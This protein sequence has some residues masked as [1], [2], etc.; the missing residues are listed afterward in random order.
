MKRFVT[1]SIKKVQ[2]I[3]NN[4]PMFKRHRYAIECE[5]ITKAYDVAKDVYSFDGIQ[6]LRISK[7]I[8]DKT[9]IILPQKYYNII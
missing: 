5:N 6:Y 4:V 7:T 1:F 2:K 9:R 8:R 3:V